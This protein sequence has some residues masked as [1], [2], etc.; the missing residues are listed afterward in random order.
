MSSRCCRCPRGIDNKRETFV[1]RLLDGA[2]IGNAEPPMPTTRDEYASRATS[3]G[4]PVAL[5]RPPGRSRS[6]WYSNYVNL[7]IDKDVLDLSHV[8]QREMLPRLLSQLWPQGLVR[9][10]TS[11]PSAAS[12]DWRN[13]P[14]TGHAQDRN[15]SRAPSMA[16]R[17]LVN[18][19]YAGP[20]NS[21]CR[22]S[23]TA[24]STGRR[25]FRVR[26][27]VLIA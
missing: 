22:R 2:G 8:R 5:R 3:G 21:L 12:P 1:A 15:M 19:R 9:F 13:P 7:V 25:A 18:H 26:P 17:T 20:N 24:D 10:S 16:P 23:A 27:R 14:P 4:M 6:R 11:P